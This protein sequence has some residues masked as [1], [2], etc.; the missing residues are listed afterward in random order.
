M[1]D[2]DNPISVR[3]KRRI[4]DSLLELMHERPFSKIS[5]KDIV[6]RAGLTRQTF[7]HNFNSKEEVLMNKEGELFEEFMQYLMK[8]QV[9]EWN[10]IVLYYFRFWQ[11]NADF[12]R[13]LIKN[14]LVFVLESKA[15]DY[16]EAIRGNVK[17]EQTELTELEF[18]YIYSF[19][20]GAIIN[21]L[22]SWVQSGMVLSPQEMT[23]LVMK[24]FDGTIMKKYGNLVWFPQEKKVQEPSEPETNN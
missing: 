12:A 24:L 21:M 9:T 22:V 23:N 3:S 8:N 14:N 17:M 1:G 18:S 5:I 7:Y 19:C 10:N 13:L 15:P 11:H 20:S 4:T 16:Y 6:E 2:R